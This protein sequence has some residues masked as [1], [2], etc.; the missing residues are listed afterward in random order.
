MQINKAS[1]PLLARRARGPVPF[2]PHNSGIRKGGDWINVQD[3]S[4][5]IATRCTRTLSSSDRNRVVSNAASSATAETN[6]ASHV[7]SQPR[8]PTSAP[9]FQDAITK[10]QAYW[11]GVG[12]ALWLPHNTEVTQ[13]DC[14]AS[15]H[16]AYGASLSTYIHEG[17]AR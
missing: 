12:C 16:G 6:H 10:L 17:G 15:M 7:S 14:R 8:S 1:S 13:G 5:P 4:F 2:R 3:Y 11:A 9:S